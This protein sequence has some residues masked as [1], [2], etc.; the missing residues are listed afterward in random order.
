MRYD[1]YE[2]LNASQFIVTNLTAA[3]PSLAQRLFRIGDAENVESR[4]V[5]WQCY[6]AMAETDQPKLLMGINL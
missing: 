1:D 2:F 6:A 3:R 4:C 5:L